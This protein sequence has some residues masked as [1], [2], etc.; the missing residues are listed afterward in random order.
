[1]IEPFD[2]IVTQWHISAGLESLLW[3][4]FM[5]VATLRVRQLLDST[6]ILELLYRAIEKADIYSCEDL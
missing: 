3:V 2:D 1:V 6:S 5:V 4:L